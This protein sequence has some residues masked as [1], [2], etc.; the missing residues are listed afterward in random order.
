MTHSA[1]KL[2]DLARSVVEPMGYEL[3]GVEHL[4]HGGSHGGSILRVYIDAEQGINLDDCS[5]VSHQLSGVLEVEDPI[6]GHYDLEVSSPGLD[7]PLFGVEHY[8]R[9]RGRRAKVRLG[10]KLE[11]RRNF[12]GLLAGVEGDRLRLEVEGAVRELPLAM[13]ESAR[14]VPEF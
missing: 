3:V 7:R 2:V 8:E 13:I 14:L 1:H 4:P 6:P 5:A 10:V 12:E 9:F 11:G